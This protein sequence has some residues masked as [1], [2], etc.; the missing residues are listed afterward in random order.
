MRCSVGLNLNRGPVWESKVCIP[1]HLDILLTYRVWAQYPYLASNTVNEYG[2]NAEVKICG[3]GSCDP[4]VLDGKHYNV[5]CSDH[6]FCASADGGS[7]LVWKQCADHWMPNPD[8]MGSGLFSYDNIGTSMWLLFSHITL[9]GW[10]STM[11]LVGPRPPESNLLAHIDGDGKIAIQMWFSRIFHVFFVFIGAFVVVQLGL[12]IIAIKYFAAQEEELTLKARIALDEEAILQT[13]EVIRSR[14]NSSKPQTKSFSIVQK[15]GAFTPAN[16]IRSLKVLGA[17]LYNIVPGFKA[18]YTFLADSLFRFRIGCRVVCMHSWFQPFILTCIC[19]NTVCM[20]IEYHDV[21]QFETNICQ[22]RCDLDARLPANATCTGPLFNRTRDIDGKGQRVRPAQKSFCFLES[23]LAVADSVLCSNLQSAAACYASSAKCFWVP[24]K[25]GLTG[26][27]DE[28]YKSCKLGLY[29]ADE[30][31]LGSGALSLRQLCGGGEEGTNRCP[32]FDQK[33]SLILDQINIVLTIFFILEMA[34]KMLAMG[35]FAPSVE[36]K[37]VVRSGTARSI[38]QESRGTLITASSF[39]DRHADFVFEGYFNDGW[40][41]FDFAIV[42]FS[43]AEFIISAVGGGQTSSGMFS[44]LRTMRLFRLLKLFRHWHQMQKLVGA[45]GTA[46]KSLNLVLF[47]Y[48]IVAYI[49]ALL[50][51]EIFATHFKTVKTGNPRSNFDNFLTSFLTVFQIV[52]AENW[53]T[54]AYNCIFVNHSQPSDWGFALLPFVYVLIGNYVIMNLFVAILLSKMTDE[55]VDEALNVQN[56]DLEQ[57]DVENPFASAKAPGSAVFAKLATMSR[58]SSRIL[59]LARKFKE[60]VA[61]TVP[62]SRTRRSLDPDSDAPTPQFVVDGA[63]NSLKLHKDD[64]DVNIMRIAYHETFLRHFL[65]VNNKHGEPK[66]IKLP[67]HNAL[68]I[69]SPYSSL[70]QSMAYISHH[71][72]FDKAIIGFIL[73]SSIQ[74]MIEAFEPA[75]EVRAQYCGHVYT[76]GLDCTNRY[77]GQVSFPSTREDYLCPKRRDEKGFGI[78][79]GAC[80]SADEAPCCKD[81]ALYEW[82]QQIDNVFTVIFLFEMIIKIITEGAWFHPRAY[83]RSV[84]NVLDAGVVIVSIVA[85]IFKLIGTASD[86][87]ALKTLRCLRVLRPLRIVKRNPQLKT[88]VICIIGSLPAL[89]TSA[90]VLLVYIFVIAMLMTSMF[91]GTFF[92]CY[93]LQDQIYYGS[94]I[95]P[96]G[97]LYTSDQ[98]LSGPSSVPTIIECVTKTQGL[99]VWHNAASTFD[100]VLSAMQTLFEMSTT[101]GWLQVMASTT[102]SLGSPGLTPVPNTN[103]VY[104]VLCLLHVMVGFFVMLNLVVSGIINN[105][106]RIK[107]RQ[108]GL[109][110][111]MTEEQKQWRENVNRIR[112]LKPRKRE[113]AFKNPW[114]NIFKSIANSGKFETTLSWIIFANFVVMLSKSHDESCQV[115]ANMVWVNVGFAAIFAIEAAIKVIGLG[116]NFYF[117]DSY[118]RL[119]FLLVLVSFVVL[120]FDFA[121]E[122]HLCTG[123]A[124]SKQSVP[125][126]TALRAIRIARLFRLV[127]RF[128]GV[129]DMISTLYSSLSVL[130]NILMLIVLILFIMAVLGTMLFWNVN[131]QQ[132]LYGGVDQDGNYERF[133]LAFFL[134]FRQATGESWN[135]IM[136]YCS[137]PELVLACADTRDDYREAIGCGSSAMGRIYHLLW[138]IFGTYMLMQLVAAVI[139]EKFEDLVKSE[140]AVISQKSLDQFVDKWSVFDPDGTSFIT[141]VQLTQLIIELNPPLGI[142][143]TQNASTLKLMAVVKDLDIPVRQ[144]AIPEFGSAEPGNTSKYAACVKYHDTLI[145]L[146]RRAHTIHPEDEKLQDMSSSESDTSQDEAED[147]YAEPTDP[148]QVVESRHHHRH[149]QESQA[150]STLP[151]G[152]D[153]GP[154]REEIS[155]QYSNATVAQDYA[156]RQLQYAC[157]A[158]RENRLQVNKGRDLQVSI[159]LNM[160][161]FSLSRQNT[162]GL[163]DCIAE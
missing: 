93:G 148:E 116:V 123:G 59:N 103:P 46:V 55:D 143:S 109:S 120:A 137:E 71:P 47:L 92:R 28:S 111:L 48:L 70:R 133:D 142:N 51:M 117:M 130:A 128:K 102:D 5:I 11:Y 14:E 7:N 15:T 152:Q 66:Y 20:A 23:N 12:A 75:Y 33:V 65:Q 36:Q 125:A 162:S 76:S 1:D 119:D 106:V 87:K 104:S 29:S 50:A 19:L 41:F 131:Q 10:T 88:T 124:E 136:R 127:A 114:R 83:L 115:K 72:L 81:V 96:L 26:S 98:A 52:T 43:I 3:V 121:Q 108:D 34:L 159:P 161:A 134:L 147:I 99:G 113:R 67:A 9:E 150:S 22:R 101:E 73:F 94:S 77:P 146:V 38:F 154:E 60:K 100:N 17:K 129:Q 79:F 86:V 138:Q 35:F 30:F 85:W 27:S 144:M 56:E 2:W 156:A 31:G 110:P 37:G 24:A 4:V 32:A 141:V 135:A 68:C 69:F 6:P 122:E 97:N 105:Y 90:V 126:V 58:E 39:R 57:T 158:W 153:E 44:V 139:L 13:E 107:N 157:I 61:R 160:K 54:I 63:L 74:L 8:D 155:M 62:L 18:F 49:M 118:N 140:V 91:K 89:C 16:M 25:K 95:Y 84:W 78:K 40:N 145:A 82:M 64:V 21:D 45:L 132:D 163:L 151:E 80:G 112:Q 53:T 42:I 149:H